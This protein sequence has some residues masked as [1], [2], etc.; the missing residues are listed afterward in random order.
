MTIHPQTKLG[1]VHLQVADLNNLVNYY[2]TLG[3][4]LRRRNSQQ[5]VLGAGELD[6]LVLTE[7][8][9]G[10]RV[11]GTSGLYHFAI[12][13]PS[14]SD[15]GQALRHFSH[16]AIR[17]G[18]ASDHAVSEA[19][20]LT[21]PE[22]NGIEVYRDRPRNEWR[23]PNGQLVINT[24]PFDVEGVLAAGDASSAEWNGFPAGTVI[25][26]MHLHV[27]N[28]D[29]AEGFYRDAL[30]FD[31]V[32]RYGP[33]ATFLSAGGYHHHIGANTW[34]G[35]GAPPAPENAWGLSYFTIEVP[36]TQALADVRAQLESA[37]VP[38]TERDEGY[39]VRDPSGNGV[40]LRSTA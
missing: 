40:L 25:G 34:A 29:A 14:R 35:V 15:L 5:A 17:V 21:D 32:T 39:F 6:L 11:R 10:Q 3:L 4:H 36:G 37:N 20:Y 2:T 7:R 38:V 28:I 12:L 26:H 27:G 1:P 24:T 13:L 30:G 23:Y 18:G 33:S 8:A 9:D 19:L 16:A 31:L 22:G